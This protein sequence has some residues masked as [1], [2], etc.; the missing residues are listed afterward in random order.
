MADLQNRARG[1]RFK[2]LCQLI[3]ENA[4]LPIVTSHARKPSDFY[5]EPETGTRS[6]IVGLS[7]FVILTRSTVGVGGYSEAL[8]TARALAMQENRPHAA[9]LQ[10]RSGAVV[11][12]YAVM[13]IQDWA[14]LV[15]EARAAKQD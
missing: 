5:G 3:L 4:G 2:S 7:D 1:E 14:S 12:H 15:A 8:T 9:L 6:D 13:E 10:W 11:A